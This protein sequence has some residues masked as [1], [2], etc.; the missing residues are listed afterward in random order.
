MS[1]SPFSKGFPISIGDVQE[2][3]NR[4]FDRM[5]HGGISTAPLDGQK[6]APATDVIDEPTQ[7]VV[8]AEV[9]GLGVEEIEVTFDEGELMLKGHKV[10]GRTAEEGIAFVRRERRFG[11]FCRRIPIPERVNAEAISARCAK[12]VLEIILPKKEIPQRKT[13]KIE[14]A[15]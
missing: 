4:V 14:V 1:L 2:E 11:N 5:W 10:A 6:W 3:I 7:Y 8:T 9:P 12:G 13:V 15:E